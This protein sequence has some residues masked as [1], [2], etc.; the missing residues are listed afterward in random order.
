M[1]RLKRLFDFPE[2]NEA[3]CRRARATIEARYAEEVAGE[4]FLEVGDRLLKR[5]DRR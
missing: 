4:A 5:T 2:L 1:A 3:M